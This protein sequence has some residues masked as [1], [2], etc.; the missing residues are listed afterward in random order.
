MPADARVDGV[1]LPGDVD[2]DVAIVGAGLTGLWTAYYL[3]SADR[4]LR[5]AVL[6][7]ERVGFGASGRNGGWCSGLLAA[8]IGRL[9]SR[10]G[11]TTAIAMQRQL[12]GAVDEVG[13]VVEA[14]RLDAQYAKG[15]TITAARTA[16]QQQRLVD[17]LAEARSFGFGNDD[18]RWLEP[19]E[20]LERCRMAG[21]RAALFTPHCAAV[22]PMRLV[23]G[24]AAAVCHR[25]VVLHDQT[26][27]VEI[28]PGAVVTE[29]GRVRAEVVVVATEAYTAMLPGRRR[30]LVPLYSLMVGTEPLDADQWEQ[31]GLAAR[32]TF[33]DA[34]HLIIYG[35]RTTDG[36]LA[37]GGRG[38]PYHF[39]SRIEPGFDTDERV[40][41]MLV[42]ALRELFPVV[43]EVDVPFHWGGPL[44]VPR[45]WEWSARFDRTTGLASA[46]GYVGD[47]VS[48]TN[49]AGRTLADLI[50]G[51]RSELTELPWAD[52]RTP[53]WEPEPL[54]WV[55]I[56]LSRRA[57]S[58][59]DRAEHSTRPLSAA[60]SKAWSR[61]LSLVTGR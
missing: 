50:N 52:H 25:G 34:R 3:A 19:D 53:R 6:E 56:N 8:G 20:L 46:G 24:V 47:G 21:S 51:V 35:Q 17:D 12:F 1:P 54:R 23:H 9:A 38:A 33:H 48:T 43:G 10:H 7:R 61:V 11:R 41:S 31:V 60:R 36:R 26:P 44:G 29:R 32:E 13:R 37:F 42:A 28:A 55:G 14:E 5:I 16:A 18:L 49:V 45:D 57:A 27:V 22:H 59:A 58:G 4:G 2:V 40:R 39:G 15:G 30:D